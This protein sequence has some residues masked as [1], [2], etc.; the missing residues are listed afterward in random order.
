MRY[1]ASLTSALVED[2]ALEAGD[3]VQQIGPVRM[4]SHLSPRNPR[5][6]ARMEGGA[7]KVS[8]SLGDPKRLFRTLLFSTR[9]NSTNLC[10]TVIV[11]R[12]DLRSPHGRSKEGVG[13]RVMVRDSLGNKGWVSVDSRDKSGDRGFEARSVGHA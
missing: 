2:A 1:G 10:N 3:V 4:S 13:P 7:A 11:D 8:E 5:R 12:A 9:G 6:C